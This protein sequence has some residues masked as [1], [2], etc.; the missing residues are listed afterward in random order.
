MLILYDYWDSFEKF[1]EVLPSKDKLH[2]TL[3][4]REI[5]DKNYKHVL[6]FWKAFKMNTMKDYHDL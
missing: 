2:N 6:N 5:S 4:K 3:T 1:K